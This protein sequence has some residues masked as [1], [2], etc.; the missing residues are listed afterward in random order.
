M[1][2]EYPRSLRILQLK[3]GDPVQFERVQ[4]VLIREG[5]EGI[6]AILSQTNMR[7]E[8]MNMKLERRTAMLSPTKSYSTEIY[9]QRY[10]AA[11]SDTGTLIFT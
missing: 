5:L 10:I 1:R 8:A 3:A 4:N 2:N 11:N 6:S 9:S 7:L